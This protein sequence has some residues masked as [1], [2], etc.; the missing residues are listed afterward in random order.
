M[1]RFGGDALRLRQCNPWAGR[2]SERVP[3]RYTLRI[4]LTK[5][6]LIHKKDVSRGRPGSPTHE[7]YVFQA[8]HSSYRVRWG[9]TSHI[10]TWTCD[11]GRTLVQSL[12]QCKRFASVVIRDAP[13]LLRRLIVLSWA[14]PAYAPSPECSNETSA[15]SE[16]LSY[17]SLYDIAGW[18]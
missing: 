3:G 12:Y 13:L 4:T 15:R 9:W 16:T 18:I 17:S 7:T 11:T 8:L 6:C 5:I 1:P 2:A 14:E 10:Y